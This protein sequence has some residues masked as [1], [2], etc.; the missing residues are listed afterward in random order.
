MHE[1]DK[2]NYVIGHVPQEELEELQ[3]GV[4]KAKEAVIDILEN[5]IDHAMNKFN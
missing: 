5:S 4:E 3:K 2:I 1:N